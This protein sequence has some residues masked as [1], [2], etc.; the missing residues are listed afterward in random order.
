M[1]IELDDCLRDVIECELGQLEPRLGRSRRVLVSRIGHDEDEQL[2]EVE[3][4][5]RRASERDVPVVG[6]VEDPTQYPYCHSRVS[7]PTSTCAPRLTP[8][9]R[10]ASSSSAGDG[11]V[12]TT[13]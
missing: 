12:P 13:R 6:R 4:A 7:S 10:S 9:R 1:Q 5:E 3:L 11:G 2:V 8:I